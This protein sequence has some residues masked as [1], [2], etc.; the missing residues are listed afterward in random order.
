MGG[1]AVFI[2]TSAM[3]L[4]RHE[5]EVCAGQDCMGANPALSHRSA[6]VGLGKLLLY[7][8]KSR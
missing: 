2:T 4:V 5:K 6:T 8:G 7:V 3:Q 1:A